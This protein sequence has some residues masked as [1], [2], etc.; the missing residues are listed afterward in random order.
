MYTLAP[1]PE[2][3]WMA[4]TV[5]PDGRMAGVALMT[6]GKGRIQVGNAYFIN[7]SW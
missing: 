2:Y 3:G 5:L 4:G 6:Y 1:M 7:D